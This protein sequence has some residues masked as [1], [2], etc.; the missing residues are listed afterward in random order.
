MWVGI[1][2]L[3]LSAAYNVLALKAGLIRMNPL[4]LRRAEPSCSTPG[5]YENTVALILK[6]FC[7]V[8]MLVHETAEVRV[9]RLV[10]G[11]CCSPGCP[12]L[13]LSVSYR[14]CMTWRWEHKG[15]VFGS[16]SLAL[17][18]YSQTSSRMIF[19]LCLSLGSEW[20][21]LWDGG[22]NLLPWVL[23]TVS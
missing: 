15:A 6:K 17:L 4:F 21:R 9:C 19:S 7:L 10:T 1:F 2:L 5:F 13:V 20:C 14:L 23:I 12:S 22:I 8:C 3:S 18:L 16:V 11:M